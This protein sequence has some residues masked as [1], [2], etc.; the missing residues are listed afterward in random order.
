M[1]VC[2]CVPAFASLCLL[3]CPHTLHARGRSE[4]E[5]EVGGK[6]GQEVNQPH[7]KQ[8]V[9]K[10]PSTAV[11]HSHMHIPERQGT[12]PLEVPTNESLRISPGSAKRPSS[13]SFHPA[14][15]NFILPV[16]SPI[17]FPPTAGV[18][19]FTTFTRCQ[20]PPKGHSSWP[21]NPG[22]HTWEK[23]VFP[24]AS[25]SEYGSSNTGEMAYP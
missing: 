25:T 6:E 15:P 24:L 20:N 2:V 3:S 8:I 4:R 17:S 21:G 18:P 7:Q 5:R 23:L 13:S 22:S 9:A 16:L 10:A 12:H 11:T 1:C 14:C 19:T